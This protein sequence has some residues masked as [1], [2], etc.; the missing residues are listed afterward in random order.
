M[1]NLIGIGQFNGQ[2]LSE[3]LG[4]KSLQVRGRGVREVVRRHPVHTPR[5]NGYLLEGALW[6]KGIGKGFALPVADQPVIG[7]FS[8]DRLR[9]QGHLA[10]APWQIQHQLGNGHP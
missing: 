5:G 1:N 7:A 6:L 10:P 3:R 2:P 4:P 8:D 9:C